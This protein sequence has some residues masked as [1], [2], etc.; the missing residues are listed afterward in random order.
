M[1]RSRRATESALFADARNLRGALAREL[2]LVAWRGL[3]AGALCGRASRLQ[4]VVAAGTGPRAA[5]ALRRVLLQQAGAL[6]GCLAAFSNTFPP[7]DAVAADLDGDLDLD[8]AAA[9]LSVFWY[10]RG[11]A[12]NSST[13]AACG[14]RLVSC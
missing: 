3:G 4:R 2:R 10:R 14:F 8:V 6:A 11:V 7:R 1:Q 5:A 12:L 9:A 13:S